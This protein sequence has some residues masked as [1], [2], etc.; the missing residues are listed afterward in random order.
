MK[1]LLRA[2]FPSGAAGKNAIMNH[3]CIVHSDREMEELT[4]AP[5]GFVRVQSVDSCMEFDPELLG[6]EKSAADSS[7]N[8]SEKSENESG[9][10]PSLDLPEGTEANPDGALNPESAEANNDSDNS[11]SSE[12]SADQKASGAAPEGIKAKSK[13][14]KQ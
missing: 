9:E 14:R 7:T 5:H 6:I 13:G 8:D 3:L 1:H 2:P 4:K 11:R 12:S 10:E